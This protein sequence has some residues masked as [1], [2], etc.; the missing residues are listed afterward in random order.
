MDDDV[1][2]LAQFH[3]KKSRAGAP[4]VKDKRVFDLVIRFGTSKSPKRSRSSTAIDA[5]AALRPRRFAT[6]LLRSV[7]ATHRSRKWLDAAFGCSLCF[8][9]GAQAHVGQTVSPRGYRGLRA[10]AS[11]SMA[12]SIRCWSTAFHG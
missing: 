7:R 6:P 12:R 3:H 8:P 9:F 11:L 4:D 2:G 10:F 1:L 5:P